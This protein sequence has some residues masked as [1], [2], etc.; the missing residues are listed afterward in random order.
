MGKGL[1]ADMHGPVK[2]YRD[3]WAQ[4]NETP[5]GTDRGSVEKLK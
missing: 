5:A 3:P 2:G 4:Q 1:Y